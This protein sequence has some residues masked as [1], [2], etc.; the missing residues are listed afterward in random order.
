MAALGIIQT[1]QWPM[2][3]KQMEELQLA[4]IM[5]YMHP[6]ES[7][8]KDSIMLQYIHYAA[9]NP[10]HRMQWLQLCVM[11]QVLHPFPHM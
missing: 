1:E 4:R 8:R 7:H 11:L 3:M 10:E 5:A 2:H 9:Q 6:Y